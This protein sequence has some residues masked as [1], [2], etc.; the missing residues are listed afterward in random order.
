MVLAQVIESTFPIPPKSGDS[1][2]SGPE[3]YTATLEAHRVWKGQLSPG[4]RITVSTQRICPGDCYP[5]TPGE[6]VVVLI[7]QGV[8][9]ALGLY[10][11]VI[12]G[13]EIKDA[14]ATFD[15]TS[16]DAGT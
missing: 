14:K 13:A 12:G 4:A 2:A 7:N 11:E 9:T 5:F 10:D 16:T 3:Y 15:A 8:L 1:S 6:E